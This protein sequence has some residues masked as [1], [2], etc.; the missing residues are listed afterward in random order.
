LRHL[1]H[2]GQTAFARSLVSL[3]QL[4]LVILLKSS[5]PTMSEVVL[6]APSDI[7]KDIWD[8]K[9]RR[10][11]DIYEDA[12]QNLNK[13]FKCPDCRQVIQHRK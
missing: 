2:L 8:V 11:Y 9:T 5:Q 12:R 1:S 10:P 3:F 7:R 13:T 4:L 6:D